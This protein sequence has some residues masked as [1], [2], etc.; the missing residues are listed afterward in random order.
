M[1]NPFDSTYSFW[2]KSAPHPRATDHAGSKTLA[3]LR[4]PTF[5]TKII[6]D[7]IDGISK[8]ADPVVLDIGSVIGSNIEYF[9]NFGIKVYM[10]DLLA[11][12]A[13]PKYSVLVD[14]KLSF[15]DEK[16]FAENLRYED[17][18]FD[19][20]IC[21]DVLDYMDAKFARKFIAQISAKMKP[22]SLVLGFFHTHKVTGT[23]ST[24]KY[25]LINESTL[26]YVPLERKIEP[27]KI[28]PSREINQLFSGYQSQRFYLLKHNLLEVMLR[29]S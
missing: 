26:E 4:Y 15:D 5:P 17:S 6:K 11:A 25:R 29:K 2:K 7:F 23:A 19:G 14:D 3:S 12:Y 1:K 10:E 20:L 16:F 24:H 22:S 13:R 21:W 18:H 9:L 27:K 28:Y 8:K